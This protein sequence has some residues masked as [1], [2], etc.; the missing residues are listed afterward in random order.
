M[1]PDTTIILAV[2]LN[3]RFERVGRGDKFWP[4]F[5][6][7]DGA[8]RP[9]KVLNTLVEN[10]QPSCRYALVRTQS[11]Q[12]KNANDREIFSDVGDSQTRV[13]RLT[14]RAKVRQGG[15]RGKQLVYIYSGFNASSS[16]GAP[17]VSA[18]TSSGEDSAH[19]ARG[20]VAASVSPPGEPISHAGG[21]R[22][23]ATH[24]SWISDFFTGFPRRQITRTLPRQPLGTM[25]Y[26]F[27]I[28]M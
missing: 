12:R 21:I 7:T 15:R 18:P 22:L 1:P 26:T 27:I 5:V 2:L 28:L 6:V 14:Q 23:R 24:V 11:G 20:R 17:R 16:G 13:R 10:E 9:G 4:N 19:S 8:P 3:L 25:G